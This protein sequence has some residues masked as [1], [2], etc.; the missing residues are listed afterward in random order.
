MDPGVTITLSVQQIPRNFNESLI[1]TTKIAVDGMKKEGSGGQMMDTQE[2]KIKLSNR[3]S[4][5]TIF[6]AANVQS[7]SGF[8]IID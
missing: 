5:D 7:N 4:M 8:N 6:P 2:N 3:P 1:S